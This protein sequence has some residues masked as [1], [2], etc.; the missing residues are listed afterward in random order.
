MIEIHSLE[1]LVKYIEQKG[2]LDDVVIQN[3]DLSD[4]GSILEGLSVNGSFFLGCRIKPDLMWEL[5]ESGAYILPRTPQLP[6]RPYRTQL[7]HH[8]E[9]F[10]KFTL[11]NPCSY[12]E[13]AD[14]VIY[15]H[16]K[17]GGG[18][19]T[20]S[21]VNGIFQRIHDQSIS[22]AL[23]DFLDSRSDKKVV[24][25]MGGHSLSRTDKRYRDI[26]YLSKELTNSGYLMVS[27]GGP[28]A[29][30]ATHLGALMANH[31]DS[32]IEGAISILGN[33]PTYKEKDWLGAAF[34]VIASLSDDV[35]PGISLGIPTWHYGHEPPTPFASHIAK[36]FSN[37]IR[38]EGLITIAHDG[39]VFAPGSAGT[40]QEIFQDAAQN[41]YTTTGFSSPMI[42]LDKDFWIH[43]KPVFPLLKSLSE[44]YSYSSILE[45][46]DSVSGVVEL[47]ERYNKIRAESDDWN[48]CSAFC[49]PEP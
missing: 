33:A 28:G 23:Y 43:E 32:F 3:V 26:A 16:W 20:R 21:I 49:S 37:S 8:R 36:Y 25:I 39:I 48:F 40:I 19:E 9:L 1:T 10:D 35:G 29:M 27:G 22:D 4:S 2:R 5:Q 7:Y 14:A 24:A 13:C 41:H 45:I 46:A 6:F 17:E 15:N 11:N 18:S 47:L 31:S 30:E 38:E 42:F 34:Q 44:G 12:C